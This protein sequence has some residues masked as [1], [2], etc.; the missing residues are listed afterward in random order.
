MNELTVDARVES[1]PDVLAFVDRYL[2]EHSCPMK[3]QMQI[4]LAVEELFVNIAHYAYAPD[5]G[6]ATVRVDV[7]ETPLSVAITLLDN[8]KPYDPLAKADPDVS[9]SAEDRQIGGLGTYMVKKSMNEISYEYKDGQN[10]LTIKK[11][12]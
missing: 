1:L 11:Q 7:L 10:V 3:A 6:A 9:L 8:G 12:L 2:E 5:V 4:D